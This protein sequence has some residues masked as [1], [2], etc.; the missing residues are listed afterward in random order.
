MALDLPT[1]TLLI[2]VFSL[3]NPSTVHV[4]LEQES[5]Q[6]SQAKNT[7]HMYF[8]IALCCWLIKRNLQQSKKAITKWYLKKMRL[9]QWLQFLENLC[10]NPNVSD[11]F[12]SRF[13]YF[14]STNLHMNFST[15]GGGLLGRSKFKGGFARSTRKTLH[16]EKNARSETEVIGVLSFNLK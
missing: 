11:L 10:K 14:L 4:S 12:I 2:A 3:S 6:D 9:S 15:E 5:V 16:N 7:E 1:L 8:L 13:A